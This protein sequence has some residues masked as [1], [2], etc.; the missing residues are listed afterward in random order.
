MKKS[1]TER[2]NG[3][4][5]ADRSTEPNNDRE[6]DRESEIERVREVSGTQ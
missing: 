4:R 3:G 6:K 2:G 1:K 5:E